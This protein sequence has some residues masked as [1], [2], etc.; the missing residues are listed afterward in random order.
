[1]NEKDTRAIALCRVSTVRQ[2]E[3][4]SSLE[5]QEQRVYEAATYFK[6]EIVKFWS[7][8]QSSRKGKNY[9]RKDLVEMLDYAKAD[10]KVKYIIVDEPD[11]FMRDFRVYYYWQV[12]F[13]EEAG[14]KLVYAKKPHLAEDDSPMSLMEEM[15][16]VFRGESDN[17]GRINKTT[18]N[19]QA[20]V[21]LGYFPGN[22]KAGYTRSNTPGLFEPLE[23][24]WSNIQHAFKSI[25]S[26]EK[27]I[28]EA[29]QDLNEKGYKT[30]SGNPIDS[31]RFKK[32]MEDPY[33]AGIIKMSSWEVNPNGLHI[34]MITVEEHNHLKSLAQGAVYS[35]HKK[36]RSDFL[37]SNHME[38]TDCLQES[39]KHPRFVGYD[40]SNGK[41]GN[42]HKTYKRYR[43]RG[44][45]SSFLQDELHAVFSE[46][47][48]QLRLSD[49]RKDEFMA[50]LRTVWE[51][52]TQRTITRSKSFKTRLEQ[53]EEERK[54]VLRNALRNNLSQTDI[55]DVL[56][57]VD[58]DINDVT[59]TIN[60]LSEIENDFVEF[61]DFTLTYIENLRENFW[62]L[63][64]EELRW[65][66]QL[67]FPEGF[68]VSRDK[69]VYT[70]KISDF[71]RLA[72]TKED[73]EESSKIHLVHPTG[74]EPM[75]FGSASR[76]SI[77]LSYGCSLC[78]HMNT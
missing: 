16:D 30:P 8:K 45:R 71:Y 10:K 34:P 5:A 52:D 59:Q 35:P 47:L 11:R 37:L 26:G 75:A 74:F 62:S 31:S 40:H 24:S 22:I 41:K 39:A 18:T 36:F 43:C 60:E 27:S 20:R 42:S 53:L 12:K 13:R 72:T 51:Q 49:S 63:D 76:R 7:I 1:M 25:I 65:C 64:A 3:E 61:V 73:P 9:Q 46:V 15:F 67:L 66:K 29:V 14:V 68:S 19:M 50:A 58:K 57:T 69:K 54:N 6:A 2:G 55:E 44:C 23:P 77:Q 56:E 33:Y 21:K 48:L 4:G 70:P 38:C 78:V 17:E 28:K 32:M